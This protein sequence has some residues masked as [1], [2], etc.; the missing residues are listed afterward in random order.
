MCGDTSRPLGGFHRSH[1][2]ESKIL[3]R[4]KANWCNHCGQNVIITYEDPLLKTCNLCGN[5]LEIFNSSSSS[6]Q[7]TTVFNNAAGQSQVPRTH[8]ETIIPLDVIYRAAEL[9]TVAVNTNFTQDYRTELVY[10][11]CFYSTCR[12]KK[13]PFL[14]FH[15]SSYLRVS[16]YEL[17]YVH[18][19]FTEI[20]GF[21]VSKDL[22]CETLLDPS[23][24][25]PSFSNCLFKG[26]YDEA[27]MNTARNIIAGKDWIQ[28]GQRL[29]EI[30]G[31][32][33][34]TAALSHNIKCSETDIEDIVNSCQALVLFFSPAKN[35]FINLR[36]ALQIPDV[37]GDVIDMAAQFFTM[38]VEQ[39]FTIRCRIELVKASCLYLTCREKNLTFLLIDFSSL[40]QV[41][42]YELGSVYLQLC[43]ILNIAEYRNYEQ[44][45]D[46]SVFIPSFSKCLLKETYNGAVLRTARDIIA[47]MKR[48]WIQSGWKSS[49]I[50]GAALYTAALSN[51]LNCSKTDTVDI[52]HQ[53]E[54]AVIQRLIQF[55][56]T[57]TES[58]NVD[59]L[60][61]KERENLTRK[62]TYMHE[63]GML[64]MHHGCKLFGYGLCQ[65]CYNDFIIVSGGLV[66]GSNPCGFPHIEE[67]TIDYYHELLVELFDPV[68]LERS[69]ICI[70][71]GESMKCAKEASSLMEALKQTGGQRLLDAQK[72]M[73]VAI[74]SLG[75]ARIIVDESSSEIQKIE[76]N[77]HLEEKD[78]KYG[79]FYVRKRKKSQQ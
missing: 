72:E 35:E 24:L 64:C 76:E 59:E 75:A 42:I 50:C 74:T 8:S 60:T 10:A 63:D 29:S 27:V 71:L 55:G 18:L 32:A 14:L 15:F 1:H 44:I 66:G 19:K 25:I 40:L 52:M 4:L 3:L 61:E 69:Q 22:N 46:P 78:R 56:D 39:N 12:E 77:L 30:C 54:A 17:G 62:L 13:L 73:Q 20:L 34:Y 33:L 58:S 41:S 65:S 31:Q 79:R 7:V 21:P 67:G 26:T 68:L 57:H 11:S 37:G 9:F 36:D 51:G 5:T 48:D 49:D 45:L 28:A 43:Q 6:T 53:L 70:L 23:I 47:S 38:A 2:L 16:I